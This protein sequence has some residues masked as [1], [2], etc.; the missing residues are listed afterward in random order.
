MLQTAN[1]VSADYD[2]IEGFFEDLN[3]YLHRLKIWELKVPPIP[4]LKEIITEVFTSVLVLCG[5]CAKYVK[6]K[7][8]GN[9]HSYL[10]LHG[11]VPKVR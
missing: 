7:R 1:A 8:I 5:I 6:T 3:S 4:E 9:Y 10:I 2:K 11:K